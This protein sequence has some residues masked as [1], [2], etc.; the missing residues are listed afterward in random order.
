MIRDIG[1]TDNEM[2]QVDQE[3]V[4]EWLEGAAPWE[5]WAVNHIANL[6][7]DH[8]SEVQDG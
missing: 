3:C 2:Q 7:S 6:R 4:Q 1:L 8:T 5:I